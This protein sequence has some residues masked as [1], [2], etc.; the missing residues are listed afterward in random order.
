MKTNILPAFIVAAALV[1]AAGSGSPALADNTAATYHQ[2]ALI[3][4]P[5]SP[6]MSFDISFVERSSQTYYLADRSNKGVDIV[7][8][9]SNQFETRVTGFVGFTGS[10]DT[11]GPNGIVVVH[12]R[13]ELWAGDG[14][15][16]V[17]VIDLGTDSI[18][19]SISTGGTARADE[20]AYDQKDKL[21]LVSNDADAPPFATFIDTQTRTIVGKIPLA[22]ATN[23]VEQPVWDPATHFFYMSIPQIGA[24]PFSGGVA[25]I[26]PRTRSL[27]RTFPVKNCQPAGLALGPK[28]HLLLGC[29]ADAIA[30]GAPAQTQVMDARTGSIVA[31]IT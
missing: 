5:G 16:S 4:V 19:D 23:G 20:I 14:D 22:D 6:L 31:I 15:S 29:S 13:D 8:A 24:D 7:D 10:N 17:K 25:V 18:V 28:Q 21:I 1:L 27:V 30:A 11:S 9:S 2:I 12:D 3:T 26:D